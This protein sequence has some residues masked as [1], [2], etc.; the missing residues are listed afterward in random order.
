[1]CLPRRRK[2]VECFLYREAIVMAAVGVIVG[3]QKSIHGGSQRGDELRSRG[4]SWHRPSRKARGASGDPAGTRRHSMSGHLSKYF[5][6][7]TELPLDQI[8]GLP[9]AINGTIDHGLGIK[10]ASRTELLSDFA[11]ANITS[12]YFSL[13]VYLFSLHLSHDRL[14]KLISPLLLFTNNLIP[15]LESFLEDQCSLSSALTV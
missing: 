11:L 5:L 15:P 3:F 10:Q 7:V 9:E 8:D 4:P 1:M 13:I 2:E 12:E 14:A 6:S